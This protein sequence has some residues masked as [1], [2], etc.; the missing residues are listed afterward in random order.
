M[1]A[2]AVNEVRAICSNQCDSLR[3]V[4]ARL[5]VWGVFLFALGFGG[6]GFCLLFFFFFAFTQPSKHSRTVSLPP[7]AHAVGKALIP[8]LFPVS[9]GA[10][11]T[12]PDRAGVPPDLAPGIHMKIPSGRAEAGDALSVAG[13]QRFP[14]GSEK[15]AG[16]VPVLPS[17]PARPP[18]GISEVRGWDAASAALAAGHAY[19][20]ASPRGDAQGKE[21]RSSPPVLYPGSLF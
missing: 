7:P 9:E 14:F 16:S 13:T 12:G 18:C 5:A 2:G 6:F 8:S 19:T 17:P 20:R 21:C 11:G 10:L 4:T 3:N 15:H 1:L